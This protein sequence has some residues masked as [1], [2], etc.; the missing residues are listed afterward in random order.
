MA[1]YVA[2]EKGFWYQTPVKAK[3]FVFSMLLLG[4][5]FSVQVNVLMANVAFI[6]LFSVSAGGGITLIKR[7]KPFVFFVLFIIAFHTVLNPASVTWWGWL[8][9]E[10]FIYGSVVGLRLLGIVLLTQIFLMSTT[11]KEVILLFSSWNK[12]LG[13]IM[14]MVL[15][16]LPV[17][18]QELNITS[19]AQQ[20]RGLH[21]KGLK[22]KVKAYL[23]MLIPVIIKSLYRAQGLAY[24]LYLRNYG[25][26]GIRQVATEELLST[27]T[28][29]SRLPVVFSILFCIGNIT[30]FIL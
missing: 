26:D 17:L 6:L 9:W 29:G 1:L 25:E 28:K 4:L 7:C 18:Y 14:L 11:F 22:S 20:S 8:G 13:V 3:F 21:W 19:Q 30:G 16:I 2:K 10:G 5:L 12:D 24:L 15:G 27:W 23:V